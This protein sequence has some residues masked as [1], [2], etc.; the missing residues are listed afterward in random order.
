MGME[1]EKKLRLKRLIVLELIERLERE[2]KEVSGEVEEVDFNHGDLWDRAGA[3]AVLSEVS[4]KQS[5]ASK[6][7]LS[8]NYLKS[9]LQ[10]IK[11]SDTVQEGSLVVIENGEKMT[12]FVV[13]GKYF[14]IGMV[15]SN[16]IFT[17][18]T[19]SPLGKSLVGKKVGETVV[20]NGRTNRILEVC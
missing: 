10:S 17:V 8:S 14:P 19:S 6:L 9:L 2:L 16:G 20:V 1:V 5:V 3:L 11:V 18:T 13:D 12:V 4:V 7:L 15:E